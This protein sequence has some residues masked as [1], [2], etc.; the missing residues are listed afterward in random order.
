MRC[1]QM[2]VCLRNSDLP[3]VGIALYKQDCLINHQGE[4]AFRKLVQIRS[5]D[6]KEGRPEDCSMGIEVW[7][8]KRGKDGSCFTSTEVRG[9]K[10][11][12]KMPL[13]VYTV[14]NIVARPY[15]HTWTA[16]LF[17]SYIRRWRKEIVRIFLR[18]RCSRVPIIS[19][20]E[21]KIKLT[22][23]CLRSRFYFY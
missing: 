19:T 16:Q 10:H 7:S 2:C 4:F 20:I 1:R 18:V 15:L 14:R 13:P 21:K 5:L 22:R 3:N 9:V 6:D 23:L 17:H 8:R 11:V 12:R